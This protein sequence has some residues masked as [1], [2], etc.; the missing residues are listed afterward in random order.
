[1]DKRISVSYSLSSG[2]EDSTDVQKEGQ[3]G[4]T[5]SCHGEQSLMEITGIRGLIG[6]AG[7]FDGSK[8]PSVVQCWIQKGEQVGRGGN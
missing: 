5:N 8:E 2:R 1:M 7:T 6:G 4:C 3:G